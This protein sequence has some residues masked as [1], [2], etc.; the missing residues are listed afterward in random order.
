VGQALAPN[1]DDAYNYLPESVLQFPD[2][3]AML[4]LM[5]SRGLRDLKMYPL[6]F[7]IATLYVGQ[8]PHR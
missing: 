5:A 3:Q 2:G 8:K 1:R 6:T 4:D 7:G